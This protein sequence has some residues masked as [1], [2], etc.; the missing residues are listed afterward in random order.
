LAKALELLLDPRLDALVSGEGDFEDLPGVMAKLATDP[1]G[2]LCHRIRYAHA[3][4]A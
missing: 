3:T 2:A 4:P 1:A